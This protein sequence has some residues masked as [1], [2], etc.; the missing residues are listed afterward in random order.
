M[1]KL[2]K[3]NPNEAVLTDEEEEKLRKRLGLEPWEPLPDAD[4]LGGILIHIPYQVTCNN[5]KLSFTAAMP[6]ALEG[7]V[8]L[9]EDDDEDDDSYAA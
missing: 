7:D 5:C 8:D 2:I 3:E 4:E 6:P 9:T 1:M